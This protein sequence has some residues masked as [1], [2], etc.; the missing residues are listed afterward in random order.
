MGPFSMRGAL[1]GAGERHLVPSLYC[2]ICCPASPLGHA[3]AWSLDQM[4]TCIPS[5][6]RKII[7][8]IDPLACQVEGGILLFFFFLKAAP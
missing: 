4:T 5:N 6:N 2:G 8:M 3:V 7:K 1:K